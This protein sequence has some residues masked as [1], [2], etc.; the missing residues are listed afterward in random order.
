MPGSGKSMGTESARE[1]GIPVIIMGDV[2]REEA[3]RRGVAHSPVTL[4]G[5]MIGL[6]RKY[7]DDAI[8]NACIEKFRRMDSSF[9]VIEGA[10]SEAEINRFREVFKSVKVIAVHASP[11][12]R[13]Q[14]LAQ[15]KRSDDSLDWEDFHERDL[16][17]LGIGIGRVIA[18]AD[19]MLVNEGDASELRQQVLLLFQ[20]EFGTG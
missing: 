5:I 2:V 20:E 9:V 12:T 7:G 18:C 17:E 6:R 16:R 19:M 14:R 3:T 10:R 4:G 8:A 1:L 15:R 13:F 11:Q